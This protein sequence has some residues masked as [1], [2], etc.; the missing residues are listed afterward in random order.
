[1]S[2]KD[3]E[4]QSDSLNDEYQDYR[5]NWSLWEEINLLKEDPDDFDDTEFEKDMEDFTEWEDWYSIW[6]LDKGKPWTSTNIDVNITTWFQ[7][8]TEEVEISLA[9]N[10]DILSDDDFSEIDDLGDLDDSQIETMGNVT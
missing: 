7:T 4:Q 10:D 1:M 3:V 6:E 2:H 9:T 5:N 8:W